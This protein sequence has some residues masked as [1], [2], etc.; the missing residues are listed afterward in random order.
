MTDCLF[1]KI[2]A[3]EIPAQI[4]HEDARTIAFMDIAPATRGH[5]L[6]V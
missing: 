4:V 5:C 2:V 1:C 3:R 6:I